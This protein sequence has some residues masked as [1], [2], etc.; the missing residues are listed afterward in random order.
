MTLATPALLAEFDSEMRKSPVGQIGHTVSHLAGAVRVTGR[1]DVVVFAPQSAIAGG[2]LTKFLASIAL[3][4]RPEWKMY[5]HDDASCLHRFLSVLNYRESEMETLMLRSTEH[6]GSSYSGCSVARV[7][8]MPDL[9]VFAT[10]SGECFGR[11]DGWFV[12][13]PEFLTSETEHLY[14]A[15]LN[16]TPVG[17]ARLHLPHERKFAGLWGAGVLLRSRGR[18]VYQDLVRFRLDLASAAGY[19]IA[20]VEARPSSSEVLAKL[21]FQSAGPI[22]YFCA[23]A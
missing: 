15:R 17:V 19:H 5:A 9:R 1:H 18:G 21:G 16:N 6:A 11:D 10:I 14:L 3:T 4:E 7:T 22:R 8:T 12:D 23:T 2:R 13:Y 20:Y